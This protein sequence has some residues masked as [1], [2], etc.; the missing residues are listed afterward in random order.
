VSSEVSGFKNSWDWESPAP[1]KLKDRVMD[2]G[3]LAKDGI[4][5][6]QF[7]GK[8]RHLSP[9][10]SVSGN[11]GAMVWFATLHGQAPPLFCFSC[12]QAPQA[13]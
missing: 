9:M 5:S 7:I 11:H 6:D 10:R 2:C 8:I 4:C 12:F 3:V 13:K 1:R